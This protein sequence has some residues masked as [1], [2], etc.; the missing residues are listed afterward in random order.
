MEILRK[1][2]FIN[3]IL[4][5]LFSAFS[6]VLIVLYSEI[7]PRLVDFTEE[8]V[9]TYDGVIDDNQIFIL[10]ITVLFFI[11]FGFL[12][13]LVLLFNFHKKFIKFILSF[14]NTEKFTTV[15]LKDY[16]MS[17]A[18]YTRRAVIIS[19]ITVIFLHFNFLIFGPSDG[20]DPNNPYSESLLEHVS[21]FM[22][23]IASMLLFVSIYYTLK[24]KV[25]KKDKRIISRLLVV[26]ASVLL[27]L[28][29]EEISWGQQYFKW[30]ASGV[31][32]ESN[33]QSETNLHNFINPFFRFIY[34]LL[35]MG[36]FIILYCYWF[37]FNGDK[38]FW[39]QVIMPHESLILLTFYIACSSFI[40][41]SEIFEQI[42][43][44]FTLLYSI[45]IFLCLK[46]AH[47]TN[48]ENP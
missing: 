48:L 3:K 47:Q 28:F 9:Q 23:F 22:F 17:N 18:N 34:P 20:P 40:G 6:I 8:H 21:S 27:F 1:V 35:G 36:L 33:F 5:L 30:E 41:E 25:S 29:L 31:F 2:P 45:R 42:L 11:C 10:E 32:K 38:P 44:L 16:L 43:S 4:I 13:S 15:F 24:G 46:R 39:L 37:F 7:V 26:C 19:T 12:I 14:I